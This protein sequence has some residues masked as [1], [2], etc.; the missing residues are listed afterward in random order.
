[1]SLSLNQ[2]K[3]ASDFQDFG[4]LIFFAA[5]AN[6]NRPSNISGF[7]PSNL[8]LCAA[9]KFKQLASSPPRTRNGTT[10]TPAKSFSSSA[11]NS[12]PDF[13]FKSCTTGIVVSPISAKPPVPELRC[14]AFRF[15]SSRNT[16]MLTMRKLPHASIAMV[17]RLRLRR[18]AQPRTASDVSVIESP[19]PNRPNH[20]LANANPAI[21]TNAPAP[22]NAPVFAVSPF[23]KVQP[24]N[25]SAPNNAAIAMTLGFRL[26]T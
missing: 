3:C 12:R 19:P 6:S 18:R 10:F 24:T 15:A 7:T 17:A 14:V 21:K 1:M 26:E 4:S 9:F 11:K 13:E 20:A 25:P 23:A 8:G 2:Y 22:K 16:P 5:F